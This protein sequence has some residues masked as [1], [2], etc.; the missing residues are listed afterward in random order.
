VNVVYSEI[1]GAVT[2]ITSYAVSTPRDAWLILGNI[3][4]LSIVEPKFKI[5]NRYSDGLTGTATKWQER[6]CVPQGG[7]S[8]VILPNPPVLGEDRARPTSHRRKTRTNR[9]WAWADSVR[10]LTS[11]QDPLVDQHP[12]ASVTPTNRRPP[13]SSTF[14]FAR[15]PTRCSRTHPQKPAAQ[16]R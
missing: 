13:A 8:V 11:G 4:K 3:I 12:R 14:A 10:P 16:I 6:G 1:R 9:Q 7:K 5:C 15:L 2:F